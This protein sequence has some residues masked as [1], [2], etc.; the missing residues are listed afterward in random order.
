MCA[1]GE[2]PP[3]L[4]DEETTIGSAALGFA[5]A[6]GGDGADG[7]GLCAGGAESPELDPGFCCFCPCLTSVNAW[8]G[9][10]GGAGPTNGGAAGALACA[11]GLLYWICTPWKFWKFWKFW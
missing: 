4:D 1:G 11:A 6:G 8:G 10:G 9:A 3:E 7:F 5:F 2:A